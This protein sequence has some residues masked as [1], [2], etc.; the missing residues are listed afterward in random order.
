MRGFPKTK[1]CVDPH[2]SSPSQSSLMTHSRCVWC[3]YLQRLCVSLLLFFFCCVERFLGTAF[4]QKVCSLQPPN[5]VQ[6]RSGLYKKGGDQVPKAACIQEEAI[7][8]ADTAQMVDTVTGPALCAFNGAIKSRTRPQEHAVQCEAC[9]DD[10][11]VRFV[12]FL[13]SFRSE[14]RIISVKNDLCTRGLVELHL[15][16]PTNLTIK[17]HFWR[18]E[19]SQAEQSLTCSTW[20]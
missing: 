12:C 15:S 6:V 13:L 1:Q 9:V 14:D 7:K 18:S 3:I 2:E 4:G 10:K 16:H 8:R 11:R 17:A 5:C 19:S 20:K